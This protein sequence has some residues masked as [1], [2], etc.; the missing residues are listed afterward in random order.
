MFVLM[1]C[2]YYKYVNRII[3][4]KYIKPSN[5]TGLSF[6]GQPNYPHVY[7]SLVSDKVKTDPF[8]SVVYPFYLSTDLLKDGPFWIAVRW[9]TEKDSIYVDPAKDDINQ[10]LK[11]FEKMIL[12]DQKTKRIHISMSNQIIIKRQISLEKYLIAVVDPV[13]YFSYWTKEKNIKLRDK[14][15]TKYKNTKILK[16]II[17]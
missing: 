13:N 11:Q 7:L 16:T 12:K 5:E 9:K 14:I 15:K 3:N 4:E 6:A 1:H 8:N 2:A 10:V 17:E